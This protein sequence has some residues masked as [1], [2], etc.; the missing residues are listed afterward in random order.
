MRPSRTSFTGPGWASWLCA[1]IA[2]LWK[3]NLGLGLVLELAMLGNMLIAGSV[4]AGL[5]GWSNYVNVD[6]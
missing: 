3:Q 2:T 6:P 4:G 1:A 5:S